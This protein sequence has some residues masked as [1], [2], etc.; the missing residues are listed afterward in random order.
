MPRE[1]LKEHIDEEAFFAKADSFLLSI[2]ILGAQP[3]LLMAQCLPTLVV[4]S[5]FC[6]EAYLKVSAQL[7]R[8]EPPL[9]VH[10]LCS[11]CDDLTPKSR[12]RVAQ[13]WRKANADN[14]KLMRGNR[15]IPDEVKI[16]PNLPKSPGSGLRG[17]RR[18]AIRQERGGE[19]ILPHRRRRRTAKDNNRVEARAGPKT[20]SA[21]NSQ[22]RGLPH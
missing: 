6:V 13:A 18:L 15:N 10:N 16:P 12:K 19:G 4:C 1:R 11:L 9:G 8:G 14:I 3:P 5:A 22:F 20:G 2:N 21:P 17:V 7:E